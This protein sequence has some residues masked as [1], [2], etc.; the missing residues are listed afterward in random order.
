MQPTACRSS[1]TTPTP[2][3]VSA[4]GVA[5][6]MSRPRTKKRP[7][8][9]GVMPDSTAAS[10]LWPLPSTP[11]TPTIS[12]RLTMSVKLLRRGVPSASRTVRPF[13]LQRF[14]RGRLGCFGRGRLRRAIRAVR[15]ARWRA[16]HRACAG[17]QAIEVAL[18]HR[19]HQ[20]P[21]LPGR[22]GRLRHHAAAAQH[23]RAVGHLLDLG[24]LVGH[25][26]HTAALRG[27]ALAHCEQRRR[28]R[29][30][31]ARRSAH[32]APPGADFASGTSR[33]R[34]AAARRPTGP[35]CAPV[36]RA[37]GRIPATSASTLRA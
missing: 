10:S 15:R 21:D 2:A 4:F 30:A 35:G 17:T 7:S 28:F 3:A 11:A 37:P 22:G 16:E 13:D 32:R 8:L 29:P 20:A 6:V 12:P 33:S 25:Q 23:G 1:G 36:G 24:Q 26:H 9:A 31:T 19:A 18:D 5:S 14:F 27:D 34:P